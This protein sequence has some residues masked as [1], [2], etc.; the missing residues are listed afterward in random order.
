MLVIK[1]S[2]YN[3]R[4]R[5]IDSGVISPD[6]NKAK[7]EFDFRTDDWNAVEI[8][9]ANIY[10]NGENH[11]IELDENNQCF[12]PLEVFY[13]PSF[14]IS[15]CGGDI[16]TN[17]I[18]IPIDGDRNIEPGAY[19]TIMRLIDEHTHEEYIEEDELEE[20]T[21]PDIFDAGKITER[22]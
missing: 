22:S 19:E 2:I 4:L 14:K 9:T 17:M 11:F 6:T 13:F 18:N 10:Y 21:L 15:V 5:R 3:L 7:L 8:K 20:I 12:V 16:V 1:F